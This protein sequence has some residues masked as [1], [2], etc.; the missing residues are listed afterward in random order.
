[1]KA[2]RVLFLTLAVMMASGIMAQT[3]YNSSGWQ[4]IS[5]SSRFIS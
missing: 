2:L 1:M 5:F 3:V 4:P